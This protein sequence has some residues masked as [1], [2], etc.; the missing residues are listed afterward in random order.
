MFLHLFQGYITIKHP[1]LIQ[2]YVFILTMKNTVEIIYF[3]P[4]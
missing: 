3:F 4:E 2:V 1:L